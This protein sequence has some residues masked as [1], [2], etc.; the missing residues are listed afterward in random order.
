MS[1]LMPN[2]EHMKGI[3]PSSSPGIALTTF[4]TRQCRQKA[5]YRDGSSF[6]ERVSMRALKLGAST[7]LQSQKNLQDTTGNRITKD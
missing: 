3:S 7:P 4:A 1:H 2:H 6:V 5:V